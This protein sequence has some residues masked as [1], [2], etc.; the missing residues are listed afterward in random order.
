MRIKDAINLLKTE[1]GKK[2]FY[3]IVEDGSKKILEEK[4]NGVKKY[5]YKN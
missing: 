5:E 4:K 1:E 3:A 2:K